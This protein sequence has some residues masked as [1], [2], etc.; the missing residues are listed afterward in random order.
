MSAV[1]VPPGKQTFVDLNGHPLVGGKVYMYVP[2]TSL[3]KNTWVD[4]AKSAFNTNPIVLDAR[5]ECTIWGEGLYRQRLVD[6]DGAEIWDRVTGFADL[7]AADIEF[8]QAGAGAVPYSLQDKGRQTVDLADF[9]LLFDGSDE[10]DRIQNALDTGRIVRLPADKSASFGSRL[11]IPPGGGFWGD[12]SFLFVMLSGAGKFDADDYNGGDYWATNMVGMYALQNPLAPTDPPVLEGFKIM[13]EA[14]ADIR[15]A[16]AISVR[17]CQNARVYN[18][19]AYGF[20]ETASSGVITGD[21]N[22]RCTFNVYAH[23]CNPNSTTLPS[24]QVGALCIDA[25]RLLDG[26]GNR[27]NSTNN[28]LECR[29]YNVLLGPAARATYGNQTD[30]LNIQGLGYGGHQGWVVGDTVGE[31]L[32]CFSDACTFDVALG[33]CWNDAVKLIHGATGCH[34]RGSVWRTGRHGASISGSNS[35][36]KD[37][38]DNI[39]DLTV[40]R[41]GALKS[42]AGWSYACGFATDGSSATYKSINNVFRGMVLGD[43]INMDWV[44]SCDAGTGNVFDVEGVGYLPGQ[45]YRDNIAPFTTNVLQRVGGTYVRATLSG[46]PSLNSG[47]VVP[48]NNVLADRIS[49]YNATTYEVTF[50]STGVAMIHAVFR[51]SSLAS[52]KYMALAVYLNGGTDIAHGPQSFNDGGGAREAGCEI[53]VNS[54]VIAGDTAQIVLLTD[55]SGVDASGASETTYLEVT[56]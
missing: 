39:I 13:L 55:D 12:G 5:G 56:Q 18:V 16:H 53:L 43:G 20:K 4:E 33:N 1:W 48:Y 29:F 46:S 2:S 47:D 27:I 21:S 51:T 31:G 36:S 14:N 26:D 24:M 23:D 34:I 9:G 25:D 54:N 3:F 28:R 15:T 42:Q 10:T 30:G 38:R 37:T 35:A 7:T 41:P 19:E 40:Y 6:A 45:F 17:G 8:L 32:D 44:A 52:G 22:T 11:S 50:Q 49:D